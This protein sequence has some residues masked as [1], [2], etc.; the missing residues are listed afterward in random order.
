MRSR[1]LV[2]DDSD[3]DIEMIR[4]FLADDTTE[5]RGVTDSSQAEQ[6]FTE[7]EP[8]L[9]LLDLHM[10]QPDGLEI[11]RRIRGARSLLG[12]LPVLVLTG[13]VGPVARNHALDLGADD[14][15]TK[16]L[17]RLEVVLRVRNLLSTRRLHVD[18][19]RAYR[20][21]SEFLASMSHELRTQLSS[22]IGFSEL[23]LSD[24]TDRFDE[25]RR[26]KFLAQINSSGRYLLDL[27]SDI[28]DLA[29]IESG[30]VTLRLETVMIVE[31]AHGVITAMLPLAEKKSIR[32]KAEL[33]AAGHVQADAGKLR[34]ML[35]NLVSNAVKFTP[36]GGHVTIGA[37][38]LDDTVEISV[39]DDGIGIAESEFE[40]LF[41]E[42]RQVDS[43]VAR[44]QHGTGLGLALTKRFVELHGGQIRLASELGKGSVF[45]LSLPLAAHSADVP[46][47]GVALPEALL[48]LSGR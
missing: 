38:R 34:Q 22:V 40:H 7:F 35:L 4:R 20:H 30:H 15:L 8:D 3:D 6:V 18:L 42:F 32:I 24:T 9:I 19:A 23:L 39:S 26:R 13:D 33:A 46:V 41:E 1:V 29:K 10:P 37:R 44:E 5:I 14:F 31:V 48:L 43:D 36:Q 28:L 16:P 27:T 47:T 11:L 25:P 21:K 2:V 12:F 17:D 45:T